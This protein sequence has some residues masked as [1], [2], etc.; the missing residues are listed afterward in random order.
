M[1]L[2]AVTVGSGS[3]MPTPVAPFLNFVMCGTTT[4]CCPPF[5]FAVTVVSGSSMLFT[6]KPEP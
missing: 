6:R 3:S 5:G 2:L 4:A 1:K